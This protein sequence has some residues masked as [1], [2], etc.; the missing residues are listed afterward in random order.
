[1]EYLGLGLFALT[2]LGLASLIT[3]LMTAA[4]RNTGSNHGGGFEQAVT[5]Y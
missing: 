2:L 3:R 1:M 4:G 5:S